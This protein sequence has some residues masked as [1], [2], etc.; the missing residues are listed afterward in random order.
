MTLPMDE[1]ISTL[2]RRRLGTEEEEATKG[3]QKKARSGRG[4]EEKHF[5][6]EEK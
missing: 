6:M 3:T 5:T 1:Y 2:K 4:Q